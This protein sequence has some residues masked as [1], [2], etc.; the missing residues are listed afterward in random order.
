MSN[1]NT[2]CADCGE[3]VPNGEVCSCQKVHVMGEHGAVMRL[4]QQEEGNV[5]NMSRRYLRLQ[6]VDIH[7]MLTEM[8]V[9]N[10]ENYYNQRRIDIDF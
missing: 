10:V 1:V 4:T 5:R 3:K 6:K 9:V 7:I 8:C 2:I